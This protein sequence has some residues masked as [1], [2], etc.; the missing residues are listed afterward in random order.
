MSVFAVP[1]E[2]IPS[3]VRRFAD[4]PVEAERIAPLEPTDEA[5][6][7]VLHYD[8]AISFQYP[9]VMLAGRSGI[10]AEALSTSGSSWTFHIGTNLRADSV[11]VDGMPVA[12]TV[13]GDNIIID[14]GRTPA[15]GEELRID[16][17]YHNITGAGYRVEAN[18]YGRLIGFTHSQPNDARKWWPCHDVPY[19]KASLRFEITIP[20]NYDVLSV[21]ICTDTIF[22]EDSMTYVWETAYDIPTYLVVANIGDFDIVEHPYTFPM[23]TYHYPGDLALVNSKFGY[24]NDAMR[25]YEEIFAPYAF[26]KYHMAVVPMGYMAMENQTATS[27]GESFLYNE[28]YYVVA[29]ELAH[30]WWGNS[31]TCGTWKDIWLNEGFASYS[32][33]LYI[34]QVASWEDYR[35]YVWMDQLSYI[36]SWEFGAFPMYDPTY[37]W[38]RTVYQKGA[39]VLDMLRFQVGDEMFFDIIRDYYDRYKYSSAVTMDFIEVC[40]DHYGDSLDWFFDQ[41]V[42]SAHTPTISFPYYRDMTVLNSDETHRTMILVRQDE[43]VYRMKY[44]VNIQLGGS[45]I[46]CMEITTTERTH[47]LFIEHPPLSTPIFDGDY[48]AL[49]AIDR[50][51]IIP[52]EVEVDGRDVRVEW[53]DFPEWMDISLTAL[54]RR[55][56]AT[57]EMDTILW[58]DDT[59]A[60]HADAEPGIFYYIVGGVWDHD[61]VF[62]SLNSPLEPLIIPIA[63]AEMSIPINTISA[64]DASDNYKIYYLPLLQECEGFRVSIRAVVPTDTFEVYARRDQLPTISGDVVSDFDFSSTGDNV[65]PAEIVYSTAT[66]PTSERFSIYYFVV[67]TGRPSAAFNLMTEYITAEIA[68]H[69]PERPQAITISASPNPFNSAVRISI[70]CHSRE[71]GNPH[72]VSVEIFDI[73]GRR[74]DV[75][76]KSGQ[77]VI[78][79]SPQDD[80]AI[81]PLYEGDCFG[82]RPRNDGNSEFIWHPAPDLPSGLYLVRASMDDGTFAAKRVV[83]LK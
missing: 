45:V 23:A 49:Y 8:L 10:I 40:Y 43:P 78:A 11:F 26:E 48:R 73:V 59:F 28:E 55:R 21:G 53:R 25:V 58:T 60:V 12:F 77:P 9:T 54:I 5:G 70:D 38:G 27:M 74:I 35:E 65:N 80:E 2:R 56:A 71:N 75:I 36:Y 19:D 37:M 42:F 52:P 1:F 63:G 76:S 64:L 32:E 3:D 79:R 46:E 72:N 7:D 67:K 14:L 51:E 17:Y 34:E 15:P 41:W 31:V 61:T 6:F 22:Y 4:C 44:N 57:N 18:R 82:L 47:P 66:S 68:E 62:M 20:G 24:V 30:H 16:I 50:E 13:T 69:A 81:S 83:Y 29:H 39:A 33:A